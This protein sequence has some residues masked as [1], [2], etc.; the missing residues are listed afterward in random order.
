VIAFFL[1]Q[2]I[3]YRFSSCSCSSCWGD[4]LQKCL[5]FIKYCCIKLDWHE[6]WQECSSRKYAS[7]DRIGLL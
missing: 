3:S 4:R 1:D 7:T 5:S 2:L 6:I